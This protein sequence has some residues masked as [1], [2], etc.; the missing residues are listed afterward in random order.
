LKKLFV[1]LGAVVMFCAP[2]A[3]AQKIVYK[4]AS[5]A[6]K[7]SPWDVEQKKLAQ[8]WG[9]ITGGDVGIQFYDAVSQGG[10]EG[11]LQKIRATRP[12]QKPPLDGA[13]FTNIGMHM[14][15]PETH[16]MT[17][18]TPF[19]FRNQDEVDYVLEKCTPMFNRAV[20]DAGYVILGWFSVGW[21]YFM[22]KKEVRT[23]EALKEVRLAL[24]GIGAD[25]ITYT[26][27]QA[28]FKTENVPA[29]KLRQSIRSPGGVEGVFTVPMYGY[30]TQ[31]YKSLPYII[32]AP[33]C[34]IYSAFI[35]SEKAWSQT[36]DRYK[37]RLI[38]AA[39]EA[40]RGF[41]RV[42]KEN[43][44]G[45]IDLMVKQG[46]ILV[47]PTPAEMAHWEAVF[48]ADIKRVA[49]SGDSVID[50]QFLGE[51]KKMLEEYRAAH[52]GAGN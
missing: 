32:D 21:I 8:E 10:E 3:A 20:K 9:E 17:F 46:S 35:I 18:V 51:V 4:V 38:K 30:A 2:F 37:E 44:R 11:I 40:E 48:T 1:T 5:V 25:S 43:D 47:K 12:G 16:I 19:L 49:E 31:F 36:P 27:K 41:V 6:P 52:P 50:A 45:N 39:Q 23:P 26:F 14:L 22:T 28:G 34:P 7:Q 33:I 42:Q 13:V 24:G 15:A 29:D